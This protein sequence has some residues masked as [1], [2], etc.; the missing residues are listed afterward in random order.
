[1]LR[2]GE[3]ILQL[4]RLSLAYL[5]CIESAI[6]TSFAGFAWTCIDSL[7]RLK[8]KNRRKISVSG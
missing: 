7:E 3:A 1:V 4:R 5:M 2:K 8:K 6:A